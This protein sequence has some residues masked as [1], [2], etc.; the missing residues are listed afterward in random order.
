L[1]TLSA[2]L[3]PASMSNSVGDACD[4]DK[5]NGAE[6]ACGTSACDL[7]GP[8][9]A[10]P[11]KNKNDRRWS[12]CVTSVSPGDCGAPHVNVSVHFDRDVDREGAGEPDGTI[13]AT[14][15]GLFGYSCEFMPL[16]G[17]VTCAVGVN[18]PHVVWKNFRIRCLC[19]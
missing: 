1:R 15:A 5:R 14:A 6:A 11:A 18:L 10:G 4:S 13:G 3:R 17:L 7:D 9:D 16:T 2:F 12:L 8:L 19:G